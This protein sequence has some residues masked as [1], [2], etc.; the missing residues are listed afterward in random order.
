MPFIYSLFVSL[1]HRWGF[2]VKE[3]KILIPI[4]LFVCVKI[5][6]YEHC[7]NICIYV[8]YDYN[9]YQACGPGK[10]EKGVKVKYTMT[11][12]FHRDCVLASFCKCRRHYSSWELGKYQVDTHMHFTMSYG[13]WCL[14]FYSPILSHTWK[15]HEARM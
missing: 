11:G 10:N 15:K 14:A 7:G 6:L 5:V 1:S 3:I 2:S 4:H 13:R 9:V 12:T 8:Y